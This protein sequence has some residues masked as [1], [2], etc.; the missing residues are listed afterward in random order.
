MK[1]EP[2]D[3]CPKTVSFLSVT[4]QFNYVTM[5][6]IEL[7]SLQ[8]ALRKGSFIFAQSSGAADRLHT[9][10]LGGARVKFYQGSMWVST[11]HVLPGVGGGGCG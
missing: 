6:I 8:R 9:N 11:S 1:D 3:S 2:V 10:L 4:C 7:L 5:F